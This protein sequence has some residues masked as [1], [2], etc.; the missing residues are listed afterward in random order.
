LNP[1]PHIAIFAS[2]NGT[3]LQALIDGMKNGEIP[4]KPVLV[5]SDH[6]TAPALKRAEKAKIPTFVLTS[7]GFASREGYDSILAQE[8]KKYGVDWICLAGFMRI[9]SPMFV[10]F[11]RNRILNI[12]PSL[13][14]KYPG[15]QAIEKALKAGENEIGVTVHFVDEGVDT[16]PILM[17]DQI[18]VEPGESLEKVTERIHQL[19]H[20]LYPQALRKVILGEAK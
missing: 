20:R 8:M 14:P 19:E 11:F 1:F 7:K 4:A 18:S 15:T 3:N 5:V 10:R 6:S 12:H 2:G 9:L 17:Q 16:G 13:L